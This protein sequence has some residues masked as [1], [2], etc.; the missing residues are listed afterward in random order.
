MQ[1]FSIGEAQRDMSHTRLFRVAVCAGN[2][3]AG[4]VTA[5]PGRDIQTVH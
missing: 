1:K 2:A 3:D 5:V 4:P